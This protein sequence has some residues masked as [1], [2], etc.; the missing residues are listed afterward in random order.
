M[1]RDVYDGHVDGIGDIVLKI[2]SAAWRTTTCEGEIYERAWVQEKQMLVECLYYGELRIKSATGHGPRKQ[3]S[4]M[5]FA[6]IFRKAPLSCVQG[7]KETMEANKTNFTA[8]MTGIRGMVAAFTNL[9]DRA[10]GSNFKISDIGARNLAWYPREKVVKI[11]DY[12]AC[13]AAASEG[14]KSGLSSLLAKG[15]TDFFIELNAEAQ[16]VGGACNALCNLGAAMKDHAVELMQ[17]DKR[18]EVHMMSC[19]NSVVA[20]ASKISTQPNELTREELRVMWGAKVAFDKKGF[21]EDDVLVQASHPRRASS[22]VEATPRSSPQVI[23]SETE[24]RHILSSSPQVRH[25]QAADVHGTGSWSGP[26]LYPWHS[27]CAAGSACRLEGYAD[28]WNRLEG[29]ADVW[30]SRWCMQ[31]WECRWFTWCGSAWSAGGV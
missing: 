10:L 12:E 29:H 2:Q 11:L 21:N 3:P 19:F 1:S 7:M 5:W 26:A 23:P 14:R 6:S 24:S 30:H 17:S 20:A 16:R 13:G 28:F 4:P 22:T 9:L 25:S 15:V 31:Q 8:G 18:L 27:R